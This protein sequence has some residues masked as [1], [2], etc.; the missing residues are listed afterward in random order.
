MFVAS[1]HTED[2][3]DGPSGP[4]RVVNAML[5]CC[6][7]MVASHLF[8]DADHNTG[9]SISLRIDGLVRE[10]T[11]YDTRAHKPL[12]ERIQQMWQIIVNETQI[13]QDG[14]FRMN[15]GSETDRWLD[16][17]VSTFPATHSESCTI[18]IRDPAATHIGF[19]AL[20]LANGN[21]A[22]VEASLSHNSGLYLIGG[23]AGSG[24][25]VSAYS[26]LNVPNT[27]ERRVLSIEDP[28]AGMP[29]ENV[30]QGVVNLQKMKD[31]TAQVSAA[32]R[33]SYDGLHVCYT[34]SSEALAELMEGGLSKHVINTM[35]FQD[36]I[37]GLMLVANG[38]DLDR[39]TGDGVALITAQRL[40]RRLCTECRGTG[41][42][43]RQGSGT[44]T[45][46]K[47]DQ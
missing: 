4:V 42:P 21:L 46:G 36:A 32:V 43:D 44:H 45:D 1:G 9:P 41:G 29:V 39:L 8:L 11:R 37:S 2:I 31:R 38:V 26:I 17:T 15:I 14:R 24:K 12:I 3:P 13:P 16:F 33:Q 34:G 27:P 23:P 20:G 47:Q 25:T 7:R 22:R 18:S 35:H 10:I 40:V 5:L 30:V 19:D 6:I 28:G